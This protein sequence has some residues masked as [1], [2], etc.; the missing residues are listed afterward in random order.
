MSRKKIIILSIIGALIILIAIGW[1]AGL[2]EI[3]LKI[4]N[5]ATVSLTIADY[6][7]KQPVA[8]AKIGIQEKTTLTNEKGIAK[9]TDL[10]AGA[11]EATIS[12]TDY[13][14]QK[15]NLDLKGGDNI[16]PPIFIKRSPYLTEGTLNIIDYV[17]EEPIGNVMVTVND[18]KY[19]SDAKGVIQLKE[20][21]TPEIEII[22]RKDGYLNKQTKLNLKENKSGNVIPVT[23]VAEGKVIFT[24]NRTGKTGLYICN[25]DGSNEETLLIAKKGTVSY[26]YP[27][28]DMTKVAFVSSH[29]GQASANGSGYQSF[30]YLAT[31]DGKITRVSNEEIY[32]LDWM[33]GSNNFIYKY[34]KRAE[35]GSYEEGQDRLILHNAISGTETQIASV[36]PW[37][38]SHLI[39][40]SSY[41]IYAVS[42]NLAESPGLFGYDVKKNKATKL[43]DQRSLSVA[44]DKIGETV[45]F[46][47]INDKDQNRGYVLNLATNKV[48]EQAYDYTSRPIDF[49]FTSYGTKAALVYERDGKKDVY[50]KTPTSTTETKL[51]NNGFVSGNLSWVGE[52]YIIFSI[53][54]PGE[55]AK[56]IVSVNGKDPKKI[57]DEKTN[58]P[59]YQ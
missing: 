22:I 16:I 50:L 27:S 21:L 17:S 30:L 6:N 12:K 25:Y 47:T 8:E 58:S 54:K 35:N 51:T 4:V 40:S 55:S 32:Y 56:Y 1:F 43:Y 20:I 49:A 44:W 37:L 31:I 46:E 26:V 14:T 7:T 36:K 18:E 52:K 9:I 3:F 34:H 53:S 13:I 33:P 28:P 24:S 5:P 42:S 39:V 11:T 29:E 57:I 15:V 10:K 45:Q 41:I 19:T 59:Y 23:L 38:D 48:T 2:G